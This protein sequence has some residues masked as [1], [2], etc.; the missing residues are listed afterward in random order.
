MPAEG[1]YT[2]ISKHDDHDWSSSVRSTTPIL[3][4]LGH[5]GCDYWLIMNNWGLY[6]MVNI[7]Q[8]TF[9][10]QYILLEKKFRLLIQYFHLFL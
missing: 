8:T 4:Q 6:E 3:P 2:L 10:F 1:T 7:M 5:Q 9:I